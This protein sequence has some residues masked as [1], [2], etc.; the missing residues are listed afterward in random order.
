MLNFKVRPLLFNKK[1]KKI[2]DKYFQWF[3]QL[4]SIE[5][6]KK[7]SII[8]Q[9]TLWL[10]SNR[11]WVEKA[12]NTF[13]KIVPYYHPQK[14]IR[15]IQ[16]KWVKLFVTVF[17]HSKCNYTLFCQYF[18]PHQHFLLLRTKLSII[19]L[20]NFL[21]SIHHNSDDPVIWNTYIFIHPIQR[22]GTSIKP[23]YCATQAK[24][25]AKVRLGKYYKPY[26]LL[27]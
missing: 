23:V 5:C 11:I 4:R 12:D 26:P 10:I 1:V 9:T 15:C 19:C 13:Q 24:A 25:K 17:T 22:F 14:S 20:I 18:L 2:Y 27:Y 7:L 3:Y 21:T 16:I 8:S 6:L